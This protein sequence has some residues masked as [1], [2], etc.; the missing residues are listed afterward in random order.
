MLKRTWAGEVRNVSLLVAIAVDADGFR[1]ILGICEGAKEDKAGWSDFLKR[2]KARGLKG[3]RLIISDACIGFSESVGDFYPDANWQRCT[4]HFY[5]NVFSH[6]PSPKVRDVAAMLKAI[7]ASED[8][9]AADEKARQVIA[10]L[11]ERLNSLKRQFTRRSPT[12]PSPRSTG[13]AY[14]P[15]I[16]W[17]AS[18]AKSSGEPR[19]SA[20][21]R[22]ASR[23]TVSEFANTP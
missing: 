6:V 11:R 4:V 20:H 8:R 9:A 18:Y 14:A 7:Q 16:R 23:Y 10:K 22:M 19:S 1:E 3:L 17:N 13:D 21:S 15:T 5:R 2:L 12:T